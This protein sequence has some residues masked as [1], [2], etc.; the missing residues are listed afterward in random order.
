[1]SKSSLA[2]TIFSPGEAHVF[3]R[4]LLVG[5]L[6]KLVYHLLAYLQSLQTFIMLKFISR[7]DL[8]AVSTLSVSV[9]YSANIWMVTEITLRSMLAA[10]AQ[11]V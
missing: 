10:D 3:V 8:V 1:M 9:T 11:D 4:T 2:R 5:E 7:V 6:A